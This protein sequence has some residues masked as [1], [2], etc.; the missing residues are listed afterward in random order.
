VATRRYFTHA[1][2]LPP[3]A[4]PVTDDKLLTLDEAAAFLSLSPKAIYRLCERRGDPMPHLKAGRFLR[5]SKT[6]L[7]TWMTR[8]ER[9]DATLSRDAILKAVK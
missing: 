1:D 2:P 8:H 5:F 9:R 3:R 6:E 7:L 4:L